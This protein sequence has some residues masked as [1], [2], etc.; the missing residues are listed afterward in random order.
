MKMPEATGWRWPRIPGWR[1]SH[2]PADAQEPADPWPSATDAI[3][4]VETPINLLLSEIEAVACAVYARHG[5]PNQPGEYA[6]SPKTRQWRFL[7]DDLNVEERWALVL[8]QRQGSGWRFG[9]LADLGDDEDSPPD[10]R[11][12]AQ[13]L[14]SCRQLRAGL[15]AR[16]QSDP[17]EDMQLAIELGAAWSR[18]KTLPTAKSKTARRPAGLT[19]PEK[20]PAKRRKPVAKPRT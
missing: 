1:Q 11:Q 9:S 2:R 20:P 7:S 14:R 13:I 3:E 18:L 4:R 8:A 10:L 16:G 15:A 5:L 12:A 17:G 19:K 6:R